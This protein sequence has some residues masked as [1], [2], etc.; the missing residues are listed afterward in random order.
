MHKPITCTN[1]R[2]KMISTQ[3]ASIF[4]FF[5][6]NDLQICKLKLD[7]PYRINRH[8]SGKIW[9][10]LQTVFVESCIQTSLLPHNSGLYHYEKV[11]IL[12]H[13]NFLIPP[14]AH[15]FM[16]NQEFFSHL[17][18]WTTREAMFLIMPFTLHFLVTFFLCSKVLFMYIYIYKHHICYYLSLF[19]HTYKQSISEKKEYRI[20]NK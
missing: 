12:C 18:S 14:S 15:Q 5:N 6:R 13:S 17:M 1:S 11:V 4:S 7:M 8:G 20:V 2:P 16:H 3:R 19:I 10:N 9:F